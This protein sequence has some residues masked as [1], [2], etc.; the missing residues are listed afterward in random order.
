MQSGARLARACGSAFAAMDHSIPQ[1]TSVTPTQP[2][3]CRTLMMMLL[4]MLCLGAATGV[5]QRS[6]SPPPP[7]R[8]CAADWLA[9]ARRQGP[10]APGEGIGHQQLAAGVGRR[11][12]SG[13]RG[14][15]ASTRGGAGAARRRASCGGAA[16]QRGPGRRQGPE[17]EPVV[18]CHRHPCRGVDRPHTARLLPRHLHAQGVSAR[19][20]VTPPPPPCAYQNVDRVV[21][22]PVCP[23]VSLGGWGGGARCAHA[24][25]CAWLRCRPP[26]L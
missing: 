25:T 10:C 4:L 8:A 21:A 15:G 18:P 12:Q 2:M 16:A 17:E 22:L 23:Y 3:P 11:A 19:A 6:T 24:C 13:P 7:C 9:P 5:W 26:K 14:V 20:A 1:P